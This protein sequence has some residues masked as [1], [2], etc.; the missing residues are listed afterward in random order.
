MVTALLQLHHDVKEAR[1]ATLGTFTQG[2][3]VP[4]QDPPVSPNTHT[5]L[6]VTKR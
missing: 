2:L 3:V 5:G 4:R 1:R 6:V